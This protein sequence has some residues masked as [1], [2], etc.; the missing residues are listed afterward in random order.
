[1]GK[2]DDILGQI[3]RRKA[4]EVERRKARIGET[5]LVAMVERA[6]AP[7]GFAKALRRGDGPRI[8]AEVKRASP[9]AGVMRPDE[10]PHA[11]AP[12][13]LAKD[14]QDSGAAAMS[15]LT[16]THYFW[17]SDDVMMACRAATRLP[18][19][20]KEF[21]IDTWQVDE[22]RSLGADAILLIVRAL[23]K[24][25]LGLL[26]RRARDLGMDVLAEVHDRGELSAALGL[27]EAI[28]GINHRDLSTM[29]IDLDRGLRLREDVPASRLLVAESGLSDKGQV[30]RLFAAGI[31][32]FLIGSELVRSNNPGKKLRSFIGD[33]RVD[34]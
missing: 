17:G 2:L 11:W 33:K 27:E 22:A 30:Q 34:D 21:I 9:S 29:A 1:M 14:Y 3:L 24:A 16:D 26:Y 19:L 10:P 7:R 5:A 20:R 18:V 4:A 31:C 32:C 6:S 28:I 25:Q 15:V 23:P 8:I 13:E 12:E